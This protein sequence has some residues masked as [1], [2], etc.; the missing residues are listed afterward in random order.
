[1]KEPAILWE[2]IAIGNGIE[3]CISSQQAVADGI[4]LKTLNRNGRKGRKGTGNP[5]F[6]LP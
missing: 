3:K 1:M 6:F 4:Q 5:K 2:Q